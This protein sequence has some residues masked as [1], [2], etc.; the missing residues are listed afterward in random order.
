MKKK[1]AILT[2]PLGINYGG[3]LQNYALQTVLKKLGFFPVTINRWNNYSI[4][5]FRMQIYY[6]KLHKVFYKD[7]FKFI[8]KHINLTEKLDSDKKF[9]K[10]VKNN[11]YDGFVVGSDQTWRPDYS[12]N[13]YNYFLDFLKDTPSNGIKKIA[14]ASSFG[15][16]EWTYD[17]KTTHEVK[18]LVKQF[19]AVSVR[20]DSGVDLCKKYLDIEAIHVLDPTMLLT[21]EDYRKLYKNKIYQ[22]RKGIFVYVLDKTD[23]KEAI[24]RKV[25]QEKELDIF[26]NQPLFT[27]KGKKTSVKN[28]IYPPLETWVKAF[29]DAD[30]IITDSFHGTVF[31]IL[32]QKPFFAIPN[33]VRGVA[34][35][36]SLLKPLG[37]ENRIINSVDDIS[38]ELLNRSID[39]DKVFKSL[40][41]MQLKSLEFL[42]KAL[43]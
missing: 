35:F 32:Y 5:W 31:S 22:D 42:T 20:E 28:R 25:S 26:I 12:P 4:P 1:I 40:K 8:K 19:N 29:D 24:I 14:Y 38:E 37:L 11:H 13:I 15:K 23:N 33:Q 34:R 27:K 41:E 30:F 16:E 43:Q 39:Y 18:E 9:Y 36:T 10:H 3:I 17:E 21:K 2:Q 6:F 7:N